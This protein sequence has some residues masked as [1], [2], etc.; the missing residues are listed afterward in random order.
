M[1]RLD[2]IGLLVVILGGYALRVFRLGA[3]EL[4]GDE[5]F[6]HFFSLNPYAQI[7]ADTLALEEPHP[8]LSYFVQKAW[9]SAVG[10][11]EFGLRYLGV[12]FSVA[13]I[14]LL[15]RLALET[16]L[17]VRIAVL[18]TALLAVSPYAIWH[19]QD[20]RMYSM[21]MAL[22]LASTLLA[23]V[24]LRRRE[25]GAGIAYVAVSLAAL[26]MHYF[27]AFI[28]LA[29]NFYVLALL[30]ARRLSARAFWRWLLWQAALLA[31]YLP[32]L[33][34]VKD[35]LT[36]Y[37]GNGDSPGVLE[38]LARAFAVFAA[39]ETVPAWQGP[40]WAAA[41]VLAAGLGLIALANSQRHRPA[42]WLFGLYLGVPVLAAWYGAQA[43]PIFDERYLAAAA[44]PFFALAA[45]SLLPLVQMP[46]RAKAGVSARVWGMGGA[47]LVIALFVGSSLSL[48]GY[49][50][51]P[52]YSKS[53]G[54]RELAQSLERLSACAPAENVRLAQNYPDPTLW[55]YFGGGPD[56]IVLPPL[57]NDA[58]LAGAE[59]EA[60]VEQGAERVLFIEQ[61]ALSWDAGGIG[62][63]A[64]REHFALAATDRSANWPIAV[65]VRPGEMRPGRPI[66]FEN[67][68]TLEGHGLAATSVAPGGAVI[69]SLAWDVSGLRRGPAGEGVRATHRRGRAARGA[70]RPSAG[71]GAGGWR[72][73]Q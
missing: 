63:S 58:V 60:L 16:E 15:F 28:I 32:W 69:V 2:R 18:S 55:Y 20:A 1:K 29:Q 67:G 50:A 41:G 34:A 5:A 31:L 57:A 66:E 54:W 22:T 42:A 38:A 47:V 8:V 65:Y 12:L 52:A 27:A 7:V 71:A 61:P 30:V 23:V 25:P 36:G 56:H 3:Q 10:A 72:R 24:W 64:L 51:D 68:A 11:S 21:S 45:C 70:T 6:G 14:T 59:V 44:P 13:A 53:R 40:V 49:F 9:I 46:A 48:A 4:R 43:R 33:W 62:A 26:H 35:T 37:K 19:S 39:G 17:P 73:G